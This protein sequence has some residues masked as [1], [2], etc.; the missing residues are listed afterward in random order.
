MK[1]VFSLLL[2]VMLVMS[3][4]V[5]AAA[6]EN[7][8]ILT[9]FEKKDK[10]EFSC[11]PGVQT[12]TNLFDDGFKNVMPG[13]KITGYVYIKGNFKSFSEDSL[14]VWMRAMTHSATDNKPKHTGITDA[15]HMND[16]L[17]QLTLRVYNESK[18]GVKIFE[19]KANE[20]DGLR[21]NV[22]LGSFRNKGAIKLRVEL[23]VPITLGIEFANDIGEVDWVFTVEAYDDPSVDNPKTGD[24]IMMAVAVMTVSAIALVIL[25]I[26]KRR[27][28]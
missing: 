15:D 3:L 27:K 12:A 21:E 17:S 10:I 14:K 23:D 1:K 13:D 2:A 11:T 22:Y 26:V 9:I 18:D 19:G 16:F 7:E 8:G 5:P 25:W 20:L 28:K 24:Y 6:A 4:A